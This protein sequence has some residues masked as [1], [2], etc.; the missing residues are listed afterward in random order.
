MHTD[1]PQIPPAETGVEGFAPV[2][3]TVEQFP[4]IGIGASAGGLRT[5]QQLFAH[6][7]ADSGMAFVVIVHLSPEH[8]SNLAALLQPHAAIPVTQVTEPIK[9]VPDHVYIIPPG[10]QL[11]MHDGTIDLTSFDG[12][13]GQRAPID[14]F[15]RTLAETHTERAAAVV[16]S[17]TGTDGTIGLTRI[18][19]R[20]G[21]TIVQDPREAEFDGMPR[22]AIATGLVDYVLP[23]T[24]IARTLVE[25][26]RNAAAMSSSTHEMAQ[27]EPASGSDADALGDILALLRT[28]TGHDFSQYKRA[29]ILRRI[30]RRRHVNGEITLP[31]YLDVLRGRVDEV[32]ALLRDLLISVTNFFRDADAW[33]ALE[34]VLPQLFAGK[35][36]ADQVRVWVAGCA[37]GE[38]AYS[39]TIL[40]LEYARLR[41][42][43]PQI[44][45]FATDI[46][47]DAIAQARK[48]IYLPTIAADVSAERLATYF[49]SEQQ[50]YRIRDTVRERVVFATHNLLRD[51]PFSRLDLV[52]CRNLLIYL[53]REVQEQVLSLFHFTLL[54]DRYLLLGGSESTDSVS[55][56]FATVDK[57]QRLYQRRAGAPSAAPS[58]PPLPLLGVLRA[59][60]R[61]ERAQ[62]TDS[63]QSLSELSGELL[64]QHG[65]PTVIV[66]ETYDIVHLARGAGRFLARADGEV[67]S[68]LVR[69]MHAGLRLA[70]Q[71]VLRQA[72]QQNMRAELNRIEMDVDGVARLVTI[73]VQP[74]SEPIWARGYLLVLFHDLADA[75]AE[76]PQ[77]VSDAEPVVRQLEEDLQLTREH[78]RTTVEQY[79]TVVEEHKAA[80]EELQAINE[81][82]RAA[83]EELETGKEELQ[84]INEELIT[85]NQ[86]LKHKIEEV[87]QSNNDLQNLIASTAIATVFVDRALGIKRY[88][89]SAQTI[90]NLIPSDINRPLAHVTHTLV[91]PTLIAD[92]EQVLAALAPVEHEVQSND[93]RTFLARL[94]PYRT[95]TNH[96]DGVVLTFVDIS[97]RRQAEAE[98]R[99]SEERLRLLIASA[100]DYA[101]FT[102]DDDRR[103]NLWNAGAQA[104]FGYSEAQIIGQSGDI[105]F[106]DEDRAQN[107]PVQ[108]ITAAQ[109]DGRAAS[110]RWHLRRD[111]T[112]FYGAGTIT[113]LREPDSALRGS[114]HILRDLTT[115]KQADEQLSE[116]HDQLVARSAELQRLYTARQDLLRQLVSSQEEER[117]R[118]ARELHD[119]L[120]QSLSALRV[121]LATLS[122]MAAP[123]PATVARLQAL[124]AQLDDDIDR[125]ALELRPSVLDNLGLVAALQ[126]HVAEWSQHHAIAAEFAVAGTAEVPIR[127]DVAVTLYRI[128]QEALTNVAK[129]ASATQVS[130]VLEMRT[131]QISLIIEDNGS[132][133]DAT[134]AQQ[135]TPTDRKLGLLGIQERV[136]LAGGNLTI[137]STPGAGTTL[138]VRVPDAVTA[139]VAD[140]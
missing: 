84:S 12:P 24:T 92:V 105:L 128:A 17:G 53:N 68:N 30:E 76:P 8:E 96:I 20:G 70:L 33:Q 113:M 108:E 77:L 89:P 71:T 93:G 46:D 55:H 4:V 134:A 135:R 102:L 39:V 58:I 99:A 36:A 7:P 91:Y 112:R 40:L 62:A 9:V 45:V 122:D 80:N 90:F 19:E 119:E 43:A 104:L 57:T 47:E 74:I 83:T 125:L 103:I 72:A 121:G 49:V 124:A 13:R 48:G 11:A 123:D 64:V 85:V 37:S 56:L 42:D 50:R 10:R 101:I 35:T 15:F 136:A 97:A 109:R 79:E 110:E 132:G 75:N 44:M 32:H 26:W 118:I 98:L 139:E 66:N 81:E 137:E 60:A 2:E 82:L 63:I 138:Y 107:K 129:H 86:E 87:S 18:K 116:A 5:L 67:S 52:T 88:T 38:E 131:A 16:L 130:V 140:G 1:N 127:D 111:G 115:Q 27:D 94:Q 29:T 6:T 23:V 106:T 65:P 31:A 22:S 120:G 54:H 3:P 133:F 34:R 51:P 41:D 100:Q 25:F 21:V 69:E 114:V 126:Q 59:R 117:S 73:V 14:L 78:I 61:S 95:D 28:R